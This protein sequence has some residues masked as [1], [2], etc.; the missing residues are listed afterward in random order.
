M[1]TA[2][3]AASRVLF[4]VFLSDGRVLSSYGEW[5]RLEDRVIFSMPTQLSREPVELHLITIPSQRVDWPRTEMY[6]ES[7][8]AAAYAAHRGDADFAVFTS[9]VAKTLNEV[10]KI[11]DPRERLATAERAR[12]K[13]ADWPA[14]HYGYRIGEVRDALNVLDEVI[15]QLRV[16]VGITRF[17]LSL[18]AP[19]PVPPPPPLPPPSDAELVEQFV[20]AAS[21]SESAAERMSL[22]QTVLRLLDRAVGLLPREWADRMRGTVSGD[23]ER[24]R[25]I[26]RAYDALRK[27]TLE[28]AANLAARGKMSDLEKLRDKVRAEDQRLGGQRAGDVAALLA[29]IDLEAAAAIQRREATKVWQQREPAYR[30]YRR[31]M[32]NSFKTFNDAVAPLERVKAMSG[33][34]ANTITPLAKRLARSSKTVAKVEAPERSGIDARPD[35]Q[36]VG[37][38]RQRLPLAARIGVAEQRRRGATGLVCGGRGADVVS[39]RAGGSA[40]RH[41]AAGA[42]VT[43]RLSIGSPWDPTLRSGQAS[44]R[45]T[46]LLRAPDL[47]GYRAHLIDLARA[48][49]PDT[50]A[51]TFVLVPDAGGRRSA[52]ADART[53]GF[54]NRTLRPHIG[55]RADLYEELLSRLPDPPSRHSEFEREAMLAAAARDAE[56]G[57]HPA[58]FHLRPAL[59]AEMLALY[60]HIRRLGRTVD[61]FERLLTGELEPAAES[62]R[63]AA[64]LLEQTRFLSAAFRLYETRL[65]REPPRR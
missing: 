31:A 35:S 65:A 64:Q 46:R 24:E 47:A 36:R 45:H 26:E 7:V 38:R 18:S 43:L 19:L 56:E 20:A 25:K 3:P 15:A 27:S 54:Q 4:R 33:P 52:D 16:G 29:T 1:A 10:S 23:L 49:D 37:A 44:P 41:G 34:P 2:Q 42:Q 17:D 48:L 51:A 40:V 62:D 55:T 63:G 28:A 21:I 30:R 61:D 58:P 53:I 60:D 11:S 22:L 39:T 32:N 9:E 12:Q 8:R 14:A 13:L 6:A 59:V 5:A 50:A 57:G